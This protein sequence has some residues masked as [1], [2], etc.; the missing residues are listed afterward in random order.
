FGLGSSAE[1]MA[2]Q[3]IVSRTEIDAAI[4]QAAQ[5]TK[6]DVD[7][8]SQAVWK[9]ID[10]EPWN[11]APLHAVILEQTALAVKKPVAQ[12]TDAEKN[13]IATLEQYIQWNRQFIAYQSKQAHE[14][15]KA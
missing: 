10:E 11:S 9:L 4:L 7:M 8:V 15:W 1:E 3:L 6:Q 5:K 13:F 12:R 2:A 14:T